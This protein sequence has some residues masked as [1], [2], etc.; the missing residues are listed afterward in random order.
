MTAY[1]CRQVVARGMRGATRA[2]R[3]RP[4]GSTSSSRNCSASGRGSFRNGGHLRVSGDYFK[5][6]TDSDLR[7]RL[8]YGRF[9]STTGLRGDDG[10]TRYRITSEYSLPRLGW[11]DHADLIVYHQRSHTD[12]L[13]D[14]YR[15]GRRSAPD[16]PPSAFIQRDFFITERAFGGEFRL[17][18]DFHSGSLAHSVVAG[19]E[20][21]RRHLREGRDAE[22]TTLATG[23][24]TKT[25]LGESFPL[26]DMPLSTTDKAGL[27]VQDE[28]Q[29][30]DVVFV[31]AL[32]WDRFDLDAERDGILA[33]DVRPV[34]RHGSE[35]TAR[36]GAVWRLRDA[37]SAY[38]HYAEGFR[39]PPAKDVNL[40]LDLVTF[41]GDAKALPNPD[42]RAE[43]LRNVEAGIRF[44]RY[45][46]EVDLAVY[47][48]RY[49]DFIESLAP[50]GSQVVAGGGP[51]PRTLSLFQSRNLA[52]AT[53]SGVELRLR[54]SLVHWHEVLE[55]WH[56]QAGLHWARGD[57]DVADRPL[58]SV[59]PLKAVGRLRWESEDRSLAS[60]LR[61][62]HYEKQTRVDF[63]GGTFLRAG[64]GNRRRPRIGMAASGTA[65]V[66]PRRV[67]RDRQTLLALCGGPP[68]DGR[69]PASG[70]RHATG[71]PCG[72]D[73]AVRWLGTAPLLKHIRAKKED[74]YETD[75]SS[76]VSDAV[77]E[78]RDRGGRREIG[79]R[80]SLCG[81]P[82]RRRA[83]DGGRLPAGQRLRLPAG[84]HGTRDR[85]G[86]RRP[87]WRNHG[88]WHPIRRGHAA[89]GVPRG[90]GGRRCAD[91]RPGDVERR[92]ERDRGASRPGAQQRAGRGIP[93]SAPGR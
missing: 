56:L 39:S 80:Q 40:F 47:H 60:E 90:R 74:A 66:A 78:L 44:R 1:C 55:R 79:L 76:C 6:N 84:G 18:R 58:N 63:S 71:R 61:L 54:Q 59:N 70:S 68:T 30:G 11:A 25:V 81:V 15:R 87:E 22:Q 75:H 52:K 67:Q 5:R 83:G 32:R 38:A 28:I 62:T 93:R 3:S 19:V 37:W 16:A 21:D 23:A 26:R 4:T 42:L 77:G 31:P 33:P 82:R 17:R 43:H 69:R 85:C 50:V 89:D 12:Q 35:L 92:R 7:T 29:V 27:Y 8:G 24:T 20:W 65:P 46:N 72:V 41:V 51:F 13:T 45:G 88:Q 10:Q 73:P 2:A 36:L 14:E 57:N 64:R 34:D 91:L 49:D 48:S 86:H 9:A 53:I